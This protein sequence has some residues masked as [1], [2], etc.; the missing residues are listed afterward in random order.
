[1]N[2]KLNTNILVLLKKSLRNDYD[3]FVQSFLD[4]TIEMIDA[5]DDAIKSKDQLLLSEN[6]HKLK[7]SMATLGAVR[8]SELSCQLENIN[9]DLDTKQLSTIVS[10]IKEEFN[11]VKKQIIIHVS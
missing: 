10:D 8:M 9:G 1:M 7:G 3:S 6:A 11:E 2:D 4:D 5:L